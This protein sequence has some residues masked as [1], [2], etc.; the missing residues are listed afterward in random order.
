[1]GTWQDFGI[2]AVG[3]QCVVIGV[4]LW[5]SLIPIWLQL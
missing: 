4:G 1:M 5:L 3:T 2:A